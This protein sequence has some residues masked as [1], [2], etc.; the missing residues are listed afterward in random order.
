[1]AR[2]TMQRTTERNQ[3]SNLF[4]PIFSLL[5]KKGEIINQKIYQVFFTASTAAI[6]TKLNEFYSIKKI[7]NYAN[8][9]LPYLTFNSNVERLF[10]FYR[11][12]LFK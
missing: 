1:M 2:L 7:P 6:K 10:S 3:I 4:P 12:V 8:S 9:G 5:L 11:D